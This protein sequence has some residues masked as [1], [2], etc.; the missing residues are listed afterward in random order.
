M[1]SNSPK[2]PLG[3]DNE[4]IGKDCEP[5]QISDLCVADRDSCVLCIDVS[6]LE[7][8]DGWKIYLLVV[9]LV[10]AIVQVLFLTFNALR[11]TA[12]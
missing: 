3:C 8:V 7:I 5:S 12:G 9:L 1:E 10:Y 6:A 4:N 11:Y 2:K